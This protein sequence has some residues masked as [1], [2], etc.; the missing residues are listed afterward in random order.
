MNILFLL[1]N[2]V[3]DVPVAQVVQFP[4]YLAVSCLVFGVRLWSTRLRIFLGFRKYL[5]IQHSLVRQWIH[6]GVI[7]RGFWKN[8][9]RFIREGGRSCSSL[10]QTWRRQPSSHSCFIELRTGCCMPVECNDRCVWS[11]TWRSSSTVVDVLCSC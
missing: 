8:F 11:M 10:V 3:I 9:T 6:V 4:L 1:L 5:R 7:L 2:T